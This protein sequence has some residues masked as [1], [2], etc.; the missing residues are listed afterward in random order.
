[1]PLQ[2][3]DSYTQAELTPAMFPE[4]MLKATLPMAANQQLAKGTIV[5]I[6]TSANTSDVQTL[7]QAATGG[8]FTL[9]FGLGSVYT[10]PAIAWNAS[11]AT[12]SAAL[13]AL[14]N[15]G[16][17]NVGCTGGPLNSGTVAI[18]FAGGALA[19]Q[20]QPL[21]VINGGL[22]T[23]GALSIAHTTPG[24]ANGSIE[25]YASGN[26]DGSQT[27][28]GI[29]AVQASTDPQGNITFGPLPTGNGFGAVR[30]VAPV[31]I[32]GYFNT[33]DLSG[34]DTNA[35]GKLGRLITGTTTAGVLCVTG[36]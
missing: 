15:I 14:P 31:A 33:A 7:T 30:H 17:G 9:S 19:N 2:Q 5:G 24:V 22:L 28:V 10:T 29:L 8:T 6:C 35:V 3:F 18:S 23:G 11:A 4:R 1:M 26:S 36:A 32:S 27:P 20:P 13:Q 16:S 34:L 25:P 12:I 21:I